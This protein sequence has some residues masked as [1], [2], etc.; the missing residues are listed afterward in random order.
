[1][2][3]Y[4]IYLESKKKAELIAYFVFILSGISL[5]VTFNPLRLINLIIIGGTAIK[6]I[7]GK[8]WAKYLI[9]AISVI[10]IFQTIISIGLNA[11]Q[12]VFV[13]VNI[14]LMISFGLIAYTLGVSKNFD[15]YTE[16]R[17]N[18]VDGY[19]SLNHATYI[20]QRVPLV[21]EQTV[22]AISEQRVP[23]A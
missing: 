7:D 18:G 2:K 15:S 8:N 1:M 22:P 9:I 12:I 20:G 3:H 10:S 19:I 11:D 13:V 23:L 16:L 5:V 14:V 21:S 17:E 6:L 4:Q